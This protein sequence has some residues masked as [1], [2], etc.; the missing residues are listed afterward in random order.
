MSGGAGAGADTTARRAGGRLVIARATARRLGLR[1]RGAGQLAGVDLA[2]AASRTVQVKLARG[3]RRAL[4]GARNVRFLLR[5][6]AADAHG[7]AV[8]PLSVRMRP[9]AH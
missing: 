5:V 1:K 2:P 8:A 3:T 7:K 4:R 6:H 9:R